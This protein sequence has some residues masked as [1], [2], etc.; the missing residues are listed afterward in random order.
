MSEITATVAPDDEPI[1]APAVEEE[2]AVTKELK[3]MTFPGLAEYQSNPTL[4]RERL[5]TRYAIMTNAQLDEHFHTVQRALLA[6]G[7]NLVAQM[8]ANSFED[9]QLAMK[10]QLSKGQKRLSEQR[11]KEKAEK[12]PTVRKNSK[13]AKAKATMDDALFD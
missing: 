4:F 3:T 7:T 6:A 9:M 13:E 1:E 2:K 12:P 10:H 11:D 5:D 8:K